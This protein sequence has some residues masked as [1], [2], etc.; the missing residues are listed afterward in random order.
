ME[1]LYSRGDNVP[2]RYL[3]PPGKTSSAKSGLHLVE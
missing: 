2:D 1:S 3:M